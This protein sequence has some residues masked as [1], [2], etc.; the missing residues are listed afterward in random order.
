MVARDTCSTNKSSGTSST[1]D[2]AGCYLEHQEHVHVGATLTSN[3]LLH[4]KKE[5]SLHYATTG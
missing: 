4:A 5:A 1:S 3:M 2:M